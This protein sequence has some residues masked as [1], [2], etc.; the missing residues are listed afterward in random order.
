MQLSK[1]MVHRAC[2]PDRL[3]R[4]SS[5]SKDTAMSVIAIVVRWLVALHLHF[6]ALETRALTAS[7][8]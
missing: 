5:F 7:L 8:G 6:V 3:E 1:A 4:C 2:A